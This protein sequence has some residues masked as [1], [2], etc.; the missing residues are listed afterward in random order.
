MFV[1]GLRAGHPVASA[2]ELVT[3]EMVD[4]IGSEFGIVLDEVTYGAELRDALQNM[5][6]RCGVEDMQMF[7]V[8]L[9]IQSGDGRQSRRDPRQ[10]LQGDPRPGGDDD[11]GSRAELGRP[12]TALILTLL[13]VVSFV[14]LFLASPSFY[15]DVADHPAFIPGF[16]ILILGSRSASSGSAS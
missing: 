15:L 3:T 8:S 4:P 7:V 16:S 10:S 13:P 11:E 2:L 6:D 14:G 5:A 1:R 12:M 9:S